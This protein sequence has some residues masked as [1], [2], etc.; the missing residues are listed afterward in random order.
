MYSI[1][2]LGTIM[3]ADSFGLP[4]P[5]WLSPVATFAIVGY[6]LYRSVHEQKKG[7]AGAA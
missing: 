1:L 3:L 4:I 6:F 5:A 7:A 2:V